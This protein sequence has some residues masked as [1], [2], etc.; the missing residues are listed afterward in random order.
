MKV[1]SCLIISVTALLVSCGGA[2]SEAQK[3]ED[4]QALRVELAELLIQARSYDEA[5][6]ILRAALR[7]RPRDPKLHLLLG[8]TLR[9][10]GVY[11]EA[12]RALRRALELNPKLAEGHS[13]L[14]VL[15]SL[16]SRHELAIKA[17][18]PQVDI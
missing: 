16:T 13:A 14:G 7:R 3:T 4:R 2:Q 5:A 6:P 10:K 11:R 8:V 1:W 12:E 9:D 18:L 15:L 17:H